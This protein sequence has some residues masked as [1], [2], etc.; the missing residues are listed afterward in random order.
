VQVEWSAE[1]PVLHVTDRGKGFI[2]NPAL[3]L[4]PLSESGRGLYI[5]SLLARSVRVERIPGYG[6]HIA[7]ELPVRALAQQHDSG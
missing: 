2:R 5:I 3:P 1:Y 7:V 6:N 4:D